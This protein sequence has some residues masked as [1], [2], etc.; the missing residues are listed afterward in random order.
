[1][2]NGQRRI[3]PANSV[4]NTEFT[5]TVLV[6]GPHTLKLMFAAESSR[7][8][9]RSQIKSWGILPKKKAI[10]CARKIQKTR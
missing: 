1:M 10:V 3:K 2:F 4:L 9:I 5:A 6:M 8:L 7:P